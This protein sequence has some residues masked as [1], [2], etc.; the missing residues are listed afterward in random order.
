M[1]KKVKLTDMLLDT[2][3]EKDADVLLGVFESARERERERVY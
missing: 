1:V 3:I 2:I